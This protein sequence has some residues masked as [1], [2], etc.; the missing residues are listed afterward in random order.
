[1]ETFNPYQANGTPTQFAPSP[2]E[3]TKNESPNGVLGFETLRGGRCKACSLH[4]NLAIMKTVC[5]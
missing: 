2:S 1:M 4:I 3:E 5:V